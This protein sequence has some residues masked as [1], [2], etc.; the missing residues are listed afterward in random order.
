MEVASAPDL[1]HRL[2]HLTNFIQ[3]QPT[4]RAPATENTEVSGS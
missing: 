1:K 2:T 3:N 4:D